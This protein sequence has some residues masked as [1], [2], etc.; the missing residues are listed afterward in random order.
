MKVLAWKEEVY[1]VYCIDAHAKWL[2]EREGVEIP[3]ELYE[4]YRKAVEEYNEV[5]T[6]LG[7][8]FCE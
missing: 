7:E 8:Y 1:P 6:E 5:Q 2:I 4:R 3:D